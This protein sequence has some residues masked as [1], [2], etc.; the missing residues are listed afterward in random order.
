MRRLASALW[1]AFVVAVGVAAVG[2][3]SAQTRPEFKLGFK[4]LAEQIPHIVGEPLESEHHNPANG[5]SLQRTTKGLMVWRKA[6]NWTAFTNGHRTWVNGPSG[7]RERANDERFA[8][9]KEAPSP[10]PRAAPTAAPTPPSPFSDWQPGPGA[11]PGSPIMGVVDSPKEGETLSGDLTVAG[12]AV[13]PRDPGHPWNGI[14]D[15]RVFLDGPE[16]GGRRV[17]TGRAQSP[18]YDVSSALGKAGYYKSGF[19][20]SVDRSSISLG[21]HSLYVYVHSRVSGWWFKV[22][23]IVLD[24]PMIGTVTMDGKQYLTNLKWGA[25]FFDDPYLRGAL[26]YA[27]HYASEWRKLADR[28]ALGGTRVRWGAL[29]SSIGGVYEGRSNTITINSL[30]KSES[31][32][33]MASML[34]HETYHASRGSA[35]G[36]YNCFQDEVDAFRWQAYVWGQVRTGRAYTAWERSNDALLWAWYTSSDALVDYVMT[37]PGYQQQC[38]GGVVR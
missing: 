31:T 8:W 28:A 3:A 24:V 29:A 6:D 34:A 16:Y 32:S 33:V 38:L 11:T 10:T 14:D 27:Y 22:V 35:P 37:S 17:D 36:A 2:G 26:A 15:L 13:D 25:Y 30:L 12:W 20:L 5:D 19:S 18:R 7:V 21:R 4:A 23:N 1:I 9:E